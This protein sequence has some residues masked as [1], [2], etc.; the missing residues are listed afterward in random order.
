MN[1]T[2]TKTRIIALTFLLCFLIVSL[3]SSAFIFTHA[4]HEHDHNGV[5]GSCATCA[6]LQ[7]TE[8]ILKQ[9]STALAGTL[10][11][12]AGLFAAIGTLKVIAV[13]V[14]LPTPVTLKIR[15]NN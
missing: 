7:R 5:D 2:S 4:E 15:M 8:N 9:F 3:L 6:Q 10:F 1:K 12:I 14:F 13:Y 11:F